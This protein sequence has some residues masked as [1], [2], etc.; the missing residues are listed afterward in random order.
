MQKQVSHGRCG[1]SSHGDTRNP[2][3]HGP[4]QPAAA[5]GAGAGGWTGW[6]VQVPASLSCSVNTSGFCNMHISVLK[7]Y[8]AKTCPR[9]LCKPVPLPGGSSFLSGLVRVQQGPKTS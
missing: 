1:I 9:D 4:G 3:G 8:D 2:S 6:F 7:S 5:G